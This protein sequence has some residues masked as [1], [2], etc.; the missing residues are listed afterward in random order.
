VASGASALAIGVGVAIEP[1][2]WLPESAQW[3]A[4]PGSASRT[5]APLTLGV[6]GE[7]ASDFPPAGHAALAEHACCIGACCQ[8]SVEDNHTSAL[9]L[10]SFSIRKGN[11]EFF[12]TLSEQK[13]FT[14][15]HS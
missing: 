5:S 6:A 10:Q 7:A 1:A 8:T 11:T 14:D 13:S 3:P 4:L 9:I 15:P 2:A 12:M